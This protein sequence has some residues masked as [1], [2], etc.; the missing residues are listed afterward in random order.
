MLRLVMPAATPTAS[1]VRRCC[2]TTR[3]SATEAAGSAR[4]EAA[5]L[6]AMFVA[7]EGAGTY[8]GLPTGLR[9]SASCAAVTVEGPVL[10][11]RAV[12]HAAASADVPSLRRPVPSREAA[13]TANVAPRTSA[14]KI[15]P[16]IERVAVGVVAVV[17]VNWVAIVPV[18]SPMSPAPSE[19]AKETDAERDPEGKIRTAIP[20]SRIRIPAGPRTNGPAVNNPWVVSGN[21]NNFGIGRLNDHRGALVRYGLLRSAL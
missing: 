12:G 2:A 11:A 6:S 17:V 4:R 21:V 20:N 3:P 10:A 9:V 13:A 14:V 5:R 1:A 8:A 16:V 18:E 7:T 19:A 15:V